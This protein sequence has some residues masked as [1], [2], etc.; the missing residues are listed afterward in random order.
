M[1]SPTYAL[2]RPS[3]Q[4]PGAV[5]SW[6][7]SSAGMNG[8]IAASGEAPSSASRARSS[9]KWLYS[10]TAIA[11]QRGLVGDGRRE[12]GV[13]GEPLERGQL[14]VGQRAQQVDDGQPVVLLVEG[15][16]ERSGGVLLG[17]VHGAQRTEG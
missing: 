3:S 16:G 7:A 17:R 5:R 2:T 4:S 10:A 11:G 13:V 1:P 9:A 14:A 8:S 15:R 6:K 12:R